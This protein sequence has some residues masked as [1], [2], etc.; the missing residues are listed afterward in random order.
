MQSPY[1][2][3]VGNSVDTIRVDRLPRRPDMDKWS[4]SITL[5]NR[6]NA[7]V[8]YLYLEAKDLNDLVMV[9]VKSLDLDG[10]LGMDTAEFLATVA[11]RTLRDPQ[12][13]LEAAMMEAGEDF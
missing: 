4:H 8:G 9:A 12:E 2:S 6:D 7:P 1:F 3:P 5:Y 11:N 10:S 13:A